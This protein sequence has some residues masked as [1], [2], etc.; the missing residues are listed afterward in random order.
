MSGQNDLHRGFGTVAELLARTLG[1]VSGPVVHAV[2][3]SAETLADSQTLA[4]RI[5]SVPGRGHNAGAAIA[6]DM[7]LRVGASHG[8]G[9]ATSAVLAR[10]ILRHATRSVAAGANPVLVRRGIQTGI[11]VACDALKHQAVPIDGED[12]FAGLATTASGDPELGAVLGEVV[13]VLG[14]AGAVEIRR[15]K[16]VRTD[17]RLLHTY[18]DGARWRAKPVSTQL[19]PEGMTET[20]LVEPVV[21][22]VA[23]ELRGADDVRPLLEVALPSGRPLLVVASAI[24]DAARRMFSLNNTRGTLV[25]APVLLTTARLRH[26]ED[27]DDIALLT[28]AHVCRAEIGRPVHSIRPDDLGQARRAFVERRRLTLLGGAGS[29]DAVQERAARLRT[30]AWERD[31]A[32]EVQR[33]WLRQARLLGRV[34][35]VRVGARTDHELEARTSQAKRLVRLLHAAAREG[36]VPGGGV[37]YLACIPDVLAGQANAGDPDEALG[38]S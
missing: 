18:I 6:R 22:V 34:A 32:D 37:A 36:V 15:D 33:L 14:D 25:S 24:D 35:V 31:D 26:S 16:T 21:A 7:V 3:R 17:A 29:A 30:H 28:G 5:T 23:D 13:D 38:M 9:G 8:D 27:L 19:I 12:A 20:T 11:R 4:R 2:G 10:A 1:P